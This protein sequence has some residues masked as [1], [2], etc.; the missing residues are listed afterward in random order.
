MTVPTVQPGEPAPDFDLPLVASDA[1]VTLADFCDRSPLLLV[2]LKGFECPFCRRQLAALKHTAMALRE[3]GVETL[4]ITTTPLEASRLY[5]R[6]RSP[7]VPLASDPSLDTYRAYGV[8][9][10]RL[11]EDQPTEWPLTVNEPE[12]LR[13]TLNPSPHLPVPMTITEAATHIDAADQFAVIETDETGPPDDL[14]PFVS[15]FLIDRDGT[16]RWVEVVAYDDPA[17]Y[18]HHPSTADIVAAAE[19][20]CSPNQ[21][22]RSGR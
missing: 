14:S 17:D 9:I 8:P 21:N 5:T 18:A 6:F 22:H 11:I 15:Y 2:L 7:E 19:T 4:A 12:I 1:R 3:C 16:V 20:L 13:I 10:Y